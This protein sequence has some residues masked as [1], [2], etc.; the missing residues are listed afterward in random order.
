VS[1]ALEEVWRRDP[2]LPRPGETLNDYIWRQNCFFSS[3]RRVYYRT[4]LPACRIGWLDSARLPSRIH[5]T[6]D[7]GETTVCGYHPMSAHQAHRW[8]IVTDV[9]RKI[10][11]V[12]RYCKVCFHY[13]KKN[14]P[15]LGTIA[16]FDAS[17]PKETRTWVWG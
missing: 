4:G 17:Q 5:A 6:Q 10:R 7:S 15:W 16:P 2:R 14:E 13:V 8:V 11:G 1:I 12:S 9:P 3:G